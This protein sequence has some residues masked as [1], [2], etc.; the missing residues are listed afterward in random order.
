MTPDDTPDD[1]DRL[2]LERTFDAAPKEVFDAWTQADLLEQWFAPSD[3]YTTKVTD[4]EVREGGHY[5]V[6]M[7]EGGGEVHPIHGEYRVLD[8]PRRLQFTWGWEAEDRPDSLVTVELAET[9]DG[10]THLTL[11]HERFPTVEVRDL[12]LEGWQGCVDRLERLVG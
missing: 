9:D 4:L 5:R 11:T 7:I 2:V 10:G 12:S 6:E 8:P 1:P 3:D